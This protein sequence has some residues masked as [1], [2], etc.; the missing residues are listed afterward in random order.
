MS[1]D[2]PDRGTSPVT[3]RR[4]ATMLDAGPPTSD[5]VD[6]GRAFLAARTETYFN[7]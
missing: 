3:I 4:T 2:A 1:V 6:V 5:I 7:A